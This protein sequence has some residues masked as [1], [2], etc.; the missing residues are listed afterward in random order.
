M[1]NDTVWRVDRRRLLRTGGSLTGLAVGGDPLKGI[2]RSADDHDGETAESDETTD[3]GELPVRLATAERVSPRHFDSHNY[4]RIHT[5]RKRRA[6]ETLLSDPEVTEIVREWVGTFEAYEPLTNHVETISVQGTPEI[7][8]D[9]RG[10]DEPGSG[11]TFEI[12]AASRRTVYGVIDRHADEILALELTEPSDVSWTN[13]QSE[14]TARIGRLILDRPDVREFVGDDDWFPMF[15]SAGGGIAGLGMANARH[16]E[17][18]TAVFYVA[19]DD[20]LRIVSAFVDGSDPDEPEVV[21]VAFVDRDVEYPLDELAATIRPAPESVL[22]AVPNVPFELRP[23]FTANDGFHRFDPPPDSFEQDGWRIE[24]EPARYQGVTVSATFEGRPVFEAMNSPLTLTGYYLPPREGRNTLDWY[25]PD[26]DTVFNGDLVFWDVHRRDD[27]GPGLLGKIDYPE[28]DGTPP[29]F[30]LRGHY[31]TGAQGRESVDFHSGLRYGPY[32]YDVSYEFFA[33]G[34]L[35]LVFR[36]MG[37][38]FVAQFVDRVRD[39]STYEE[40]DGD[41]VE[42]VIQHY[43]S[44]QAIDV[45]PG[46]HD[47][48][49]VELFDGDEWTTPET[50]FYVEGEP[51]TMVRFTNPEGP[52][53]ISVP[54]DEDVEIVVVRRDSDEIGPGDGQAHRRVDEASVSELY[55]PAQYVDDEPIQNERVVAWLLVEAATGQLPHPAGI[56]NAA[57]VAHLRLSGF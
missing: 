29:G 55:H 56:T 30:R 48:V 35:E 34:I 3:D 54:L 37:P 14:S 24:W 11:A 27:G 43:V 41:Y 15:K 20:G 28:R 5:Y 39:S 10:F 45:T 9:E 17:A 51:G 26:R 53:T 22:D 7:R 42:P 46:T 16:G 49:R 18:G 52:E 6:V 25:F 33:D 2:R 31:H 12:T 19:G 36:R 38:G 32:N 47:G 57:S 40:T 13:R 21:N 1:A 23:Y 4:E 8:I 50:E 44:T